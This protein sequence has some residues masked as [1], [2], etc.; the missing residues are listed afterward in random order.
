MS[1]FLKVVLSL[2]F[3][4][5]LVFFMLLIWKPLY[6]NR[7]SRTWQ[8]YIWLIVIARMLI[9]FT[10]ET[11]L[12]GSAFAYLNT[13][14]E[15]TIHIPSYTD[16][17]QWDFG[18]EDNYKISSTKPQTPESATYT[19]PST[20]IQG[21]LSKGYENL[22]MMWA[23]IAF[24]LLIRKI[25]MY[26]S[27]VRFVKAGR[28]EVSDIEILN[29][30]AD[31]GETMG[32]KRPVEL[33]TNPLISS[34]MLLG[35]FRPYIILP[36]IE[37][38]STELAYILRHELTHYKHL[39]MFYKWFVQMTVCFHWFNPF[40]YLIAKEINKC[41]ELSCDEAIIRT[42]GH[43]EKRAYGDTLL[44]AM[45][46]MGHYSDKLST[47]MLTESAEQLKE[48]LDAIMKF[49]KASK[50]T[51]VIMLM[52]TLVFIAG[53]T[54]M[55]AYAVIPAGQTPVPSWSELGG[56]KGKTYIY[57]QESYYQ[58]PYIFEIGRNLDENADK[59][60]PDK[61]TVTL[62]DNTRMTLSFAAFY[63]N[64]I[65]DEKALTALK[66]LM[67]KLVD[68]Y[69]NT[70]LPMER[71]LIISVENV[72][73][74]NLKQLAEEYYSSYGAM[75]KF[76]AIYPELDKSIQKIY[77]D[78]M[79]ADDKIAYFAATLRVMDADTM[80]YYAEKA[81]T[82]N[83]VNFFS[84][85]VPLLSDE[86]KR[87]WIARSARDGKNGISSVLNQLVVKSKS[88]ESTS[89]LTDTT[90]E[91]AISFDIDNGGIE[92]LPT[93]SNEIKASYDSQY[94]DVNISNKNGKWDVSIS[95]KAA[96]MGKTDHVQLYIPNGKH[97]MDVNVLNGNFSYELSE[98]SEDEIH[99]IAE[100]AGIDFT[101]QNQY[102]NCD[103]SLIATNKDFIKYEPPVYP[104]YFT[105]TDTGFEYTNGIGENKIN[106][107]LTGYTSVVFSE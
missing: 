97:V 38:S 82:D 56:N 34:P 52:F 87:S 4:G 107:I 16:N 35:F 44:N 3:S 101:S 61:T 92:I 83:K 39:D 8:Y 99:I 81:Y 50:N 72:G 66:L 89:I 70:A 84:T 43:N 54:M 15:E 65:N 7:L 23:M 106:I 47:V 45:E 11:T 17:E 31:T 95:G 74:S 86:A 1:E 2:S 71:P 105:K 24:A 19:A 73:G 102:K 67:E 79:Y 64:Y 60:Y 63:K 58:A 9:P 90:E 69:E 91:I 33:F 36:S 98:N 41:C 26:Q 10:P 93:T 5:T 48:R 77:I 37:L 68:K 88:V 22:W 59:S 76:V 30:L 53:A 14:H 100:N 42:L 20:S 28:E 75:N 104:N 18:S 62:S 55:G 51:V 21:F 78:K 13:I 6:K 46:T 27:F 29:I 103:I 49:K 85:I 12:V 25:T 94:Y 40:A 80:H 57:S 32:I 96:M